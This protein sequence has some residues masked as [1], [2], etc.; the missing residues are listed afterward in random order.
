MLT[1]FGSMFLCHKTLDNLK[2]CRFNCV[3][4]V[5]NIFIALLFAVIIEQAIFQ[6]HQSDNNP[7]HSECQSIPNKSRCQTIGVVRLWNMEKRHSSFPWLHAV[8]LFFY[9]NYEGSFIQIFFWFIETGHCN[10]AFFSFDE[11]FLFSSSKKKTL[12]GNLAD[13]FFLS[14]WG[15][16][17]I[18][19]NKQNCIRKGLWFDKPIN[20]IHYVGASFN[21][22]FCIEFL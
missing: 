16:F 1:W 14:W 17:Y 2:L 10:W 18:S 3:T 6:Y 13:S 5:G 22:S 9:K 19:T 20:N 21:F 11:Y 15:F 8:F 4:S 7:V 12:K